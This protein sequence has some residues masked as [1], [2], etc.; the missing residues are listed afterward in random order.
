M[1]LPYHEKALGV[2][3]KEGLKWEEETKGVLFRLKRVSVFLS[4]FSCIVTYLETEIWR[5]RKRKTK[6]HQ[7]SLPMAEP[8]D[9]QL[10][11]SL[12]SKTMG[13]LSS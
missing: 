7:A 13:P 4:W 8:G 10:P 1:F 9:P 6:S 3:W 11:S 12:C 5:K 2:V